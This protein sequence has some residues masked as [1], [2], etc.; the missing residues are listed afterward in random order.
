M[1]LSIF[2]SLSLAVSAD[3]TWQLARSPGKGCW[4]PRCPEGQVPLATPVISHAGRLFMIG[5]GAAPNH[6]YESEDGTTWRA[7]SHDARWGVRYKASD[8]SYAGALWRVGGFVEGDRRT[9]MNDVWRSVDGRRWER[10]L[11]H[12]PWP[13]RS[14][15]HLVVFRDA[16][17]LVGGEPNDGT[18]WETTDGRTWRSRA[19]AALPRAK[20]QGVLV[21][22]DALWIVGHGQWESARN[23]VWKSS[24]GATWTEVTASAEWPA[25]TD[26]GI[27]VLNDR[28]WVVGGAG[29]RDA[30]SSSDGRHWQ[31]SAAEL[32][33][34]PRGAEYSVVF[35][36]GFWVFGGKTGGLGGTGFWDG[37][38]YLE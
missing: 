30:W 20:P 13:P 11:E 23:D 15:A 22:K 3:P 16:L 25:R 26:P 18:V 36:N 38:C 21:Y 4:P 14:G 17:G 34:P 29:H 1:V 19:A 2:G 8:A 27:A 24:D 37:V 9:P 33:G 10:V 32:P 31:R 6:V 12:A 5:D 35:K 28:L 7:Y